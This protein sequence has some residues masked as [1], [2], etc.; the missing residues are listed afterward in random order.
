M[1]SIRAN[2]STHMHIYT[3]TDTYKHAHNRRMARTSCIV[4]LPLEA[5]PWWQSSSCCA[6]CWLSCQ[7]RET[8]CAAPA[9]AGF[10]AR[11]VKLLVL[12][13][14]LL[15]FMPGAL[16]FSCCASC[17]WLSCQVR[18]TSHAAPAAAGFHA[19]V[20]ELLMLRQ[21]SAWSLCQV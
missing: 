14:Q 11:C 10:H 12:C 21:L 13:Q 16:S 1:C 6:S 17:C 9:A 18:E 5:S 8:S 15:A 2:A 7:V 19:M 3:Q 4:P 20:A